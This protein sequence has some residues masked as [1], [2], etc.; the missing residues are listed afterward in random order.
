MVYYPNKDKIALDYPK[1]LLT[2]MENNG[3]SFLILG[4]END[5]KD[6]PNGVSLELIM[7]GNDYTT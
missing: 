2:K 1:S 3:S 4:Q 7:L 5:V 6:S